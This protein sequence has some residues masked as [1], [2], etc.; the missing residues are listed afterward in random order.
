MRKFILGLITI[1]AIVT[2]SMIGYS[3]G[4]LSVYPLKTTIVSLDY[5][6][7]IVTTEDANGNLWQFYGCEDWVIND[8]CLMLM[9]TMQTENIY[10]DVI[11]SVKYS[12]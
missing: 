9:D 3:L 5:T 4:R 8:T 2:S 12:R 11:V 1:G 7:D 10:D 6:S